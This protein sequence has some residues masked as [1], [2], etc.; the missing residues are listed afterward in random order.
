M[1]HH[2][3]SMNLHRTCIILHMD[4]TSARTDP[5]GFQII[6]EGMESNALAKDPS[7]WQPLGRPV[8]PHFIPEL[9]LASLGSNPSNLGECWMSISTHRPIEARPP[10]GMF[11][12]SLLLGPC[13]SA[14]GAMQTYHWGHGNVP[15]GPCKLTTGAMQTYHWGHANVP[16]SRCKCTTEAM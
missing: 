4:W 14:A 11:Q 10:T 9:E 16:P 15:L 1:L 5:H 8:R 7:P 12:I 6:P 3:G 2:Q 13:R